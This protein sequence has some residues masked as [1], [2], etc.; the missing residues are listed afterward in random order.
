ILAFDHAGN[1]LPQFGKL[2]RCGGPAAGSG[3]GCADRGL[4]FLSP[5]AKMYCG[6]RVL[7]GRAGFS[8]PPAGLRNPV[9]G[10]LSPGRRLWPSEVA[11][12]LAPVVS[13]SP[14]LARLT[15]D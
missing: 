9:T 5:S 12:R 8:P 1:R 15:G 13:E 10:I 6:P 11:L 7:G 4:Q 2:V 3:D 14:R